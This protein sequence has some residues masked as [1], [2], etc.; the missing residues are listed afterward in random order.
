MPRYKYPLPL[1][2]EHVKPGMTARFKTREEFLK[3]YPDWFNRDPYCTGDDKQF[4]VDTPKSF[5]PDMYD[6][7]GV[8]GTIKE[9]WDTRVF[10]KEYYGS[11]AY[12]AYMFVFTTPKGNLL[13]SFKKEI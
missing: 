12:D 11:W 8:V 3:E 7:Q 4:S 6:L 10:L 13:V 5:V 1:G 9:I 2:F